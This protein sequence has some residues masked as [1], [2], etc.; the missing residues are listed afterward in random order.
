MTRKYTA[1]A[2]TAA[3]TVA[4]AL[5][6]A[7]CDGEGDTDLP[8]PLTEGTITANDH[9]RSAEVKVYKAFGFAT[10]GVGLVYMAPN[11]AATCESVT[12]YL[13]QGGDYDPVD[14]LASGHCSVVFRFNYDEG[15]DGV[16][17]TQ[18]D[19]GTFVNVNCA[20]G[21]G[22]W[23]LVGSGRDRGYRFVVDGEYPWWQ[24]NAQ[25]F[26]LSTSLGPDA[27]TPNVDVNMGPNFGGQ[28]IYEDTEVDPAT[29]TVTGDVTV[30]RCQTLTQ[31][32]PWN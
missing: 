8:P 25:D 24:G 22:A 28:F 1:R 2:V 23:E 27:N 26:S 12:D 18:D 9:D 14:V 10:N 3:I 7:A 31:T 21:D 30:E 11:P 29:G 16:T 5:A 6:A 17:H 20:M 19:I 4:L 32:P 13:Q 15:F